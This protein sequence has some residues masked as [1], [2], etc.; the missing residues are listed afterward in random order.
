MSSFY[1]SSCPPVPQPSGLCASCSVYLSDK[2]YQLLS[3]YPR[4]SF[5]FLFVS[6]AFQRHFPGVAVQ[7]VPQVLNMQTKVV[8]EHQANSA[9]LFFQPLPGVR[10]RQGGNA[11]PFFLNARHLLRRLKEVG[12]HLRLRLSSL[13]RGVFS[14]FG[15]G[16]QTEILSF[17]SLNPKI[18][19]GAS[20]SGVH[21]EWL[22]IWAEHINDTCWA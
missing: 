1:L 18:V 19:A 15:L 3:R 4:I 22:P 20:I 7:L 9:F 8:E 21:I 12:H 17:L 6:F 11:Q 14:S 16:V 5:F 13:M 10:F 2:A